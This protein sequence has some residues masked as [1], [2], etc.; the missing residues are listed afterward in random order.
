MG[1]SRKNGQ[2]IIAKIQ[3]RDAS[4]L[5]Q[6]A[7]SECGDVSGFGIYRCFEETA[8]RISE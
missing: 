6:G 4:S 1:R 7:D 5:N 3:V 2:K 8:S